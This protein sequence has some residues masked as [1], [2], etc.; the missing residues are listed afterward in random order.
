MTP[1]SAARQASLSFTIPQSLLKLMSIEL[2]MSSNHL[3]L[4]YPLLLLP[5]IVPSIK[6]FSNELALQIR[7]AKYWSFSF[8]ISPSNEYSG[9][10]SFRIDW[11]DI[12]SVQGTL[13]SL[14]Q[15]H[16]LKVP[17]LRCSVFFFFKKK[18]IYFN[19]R[20]ITLQYCNGFCHTLT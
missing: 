17:V 16:S 12:L 11:C 15:H 1:W 13:K 14:Y 8:S 5:S 20:L 2:V 9:L 3:V 18:L 7:W 6:V 4:C 10:I 19:W